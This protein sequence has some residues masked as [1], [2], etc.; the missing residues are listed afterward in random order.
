MDCT[1]NINKFNM[2]LF[3]ITG[4]TSTSRSFT[5]GMAFL[6]G[7]RF[8][9]FQWIL[10]HLQHLFQKIHFNAPCSIVTDCDLALMNAVKLVFPSSQHLLCLWHI[11]K[12]ITTYCR[13]DF[14]IQQFD[15]R[16][17]SRHASATATTTS[18]SQSRSTNDD[19]WKEFIND[20]HK[21]V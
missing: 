9:E 8:E 7:E 15:N 14:L 13:V 1:Y 11:S 19:S 17:E 16:T 20:W 3:T 2:P 18:S 4:V 21:I 5:V 10:R 12:N 6:D